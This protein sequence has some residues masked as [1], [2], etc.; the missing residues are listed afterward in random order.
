MEK[1]LLQR[2]RTLFYQGGSLG[3]TLPYDWA[4]AQGLKAGNKVTVSV[5]ADGSI[6]IRP[7]VAE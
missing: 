2:P 7:E 3:I 5:H 4:V 6:T 1:I